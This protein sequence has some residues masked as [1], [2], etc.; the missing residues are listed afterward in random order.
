MGF[1]LRALQTAPPPSPTLSE[2]YRFALL[3]TGSPVAAQK[4]LA[5]AFADVQA[6]LDQ[7]RS[8]EQRH[9]WLAIRLREECLSG[10][11]APAAG[12]PRLLRGDEAGGPAA[13]LDLEAYIMAQHFCRI[14][15]PGRTAL[16]L[17]YLDLFSPSRIADILK[18][19]IEDLANA[20]GTARQ[21]LQQSLLEAGRPESIAG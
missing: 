10:E 15:E 7:L 18:M 11:E 13:V 17:F 16:A 19:R 20:V 14:A 21:R 4:A 2:F 8:E 6:S 5:S 1:N 9:A 3:L 12:A